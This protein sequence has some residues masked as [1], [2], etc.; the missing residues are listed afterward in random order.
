MVIWA[1]RQRTAAEKVGK[2]DAAA[3]RR[4][5][6]AAGAP[7]A[8]AA[9]RD[10]QRAQVRAQRGQRMRM[11]RRRAAQEQEVREARL[12]IELVA[13]QRMLAR[14]SQAPEVGEGVGV[15]AVRH[16]DAAA[17]RNDD[18][19]HTTRVELLPVRLEAQQR[20]FGR[21]HPQHPRRLCMP[22]A[23]DSDGAVQ[24]FWA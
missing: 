23:V 15:E 20:A 10:E 4:R 14:G 17:R 6:A 9:H 18:V 21:T 13:A 22:G 11:L 7:A 8:A 19:A 5:V 12:Q 16:D 3:R 1:T 2:L 24:G